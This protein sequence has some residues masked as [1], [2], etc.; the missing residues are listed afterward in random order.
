MTLQKGSTHCQ[1]T[2]TNLLQVIMQEVIQRV[3][4]SYISQQ[5]VQ[6][7]KTA[8]LGQ[9]FYCCIMGNEEVAS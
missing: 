7:C 8:D 1:N 6:Y 4:L 2:K 9:L 5:C 3:L